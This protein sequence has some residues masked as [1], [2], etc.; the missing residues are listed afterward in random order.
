MSNTIKIKRGLDIKLKG[1]A[2]QVFGDAPA[3]TTYALK[4][5]DF[6][7]LTPKLLVKEGHEVKAGDPLFFSKEN[8]RV[9]FC[10]PVSGEVAEIRRGAKRKILEV[11]VLADKEIKYKDFGT[12]SPTDTSRE[13]I[14][15]KMLES[16]TWPFITQRPYGTI[17]N[18]EDKPKAVF[19]SGFDTSPMAPNIEFQLHGDEDAFKAGIEVMKKLTEGKVHISVDGQASVPKV[20]SD[21]QGVEIHKFS[22][23]HPAGNVGVQ[24]H[25]IAP[26]NKGEK[27]WTIS[28]TDLV[29]VGKLFTVGKYMPMRHVALTGSE[30][31]KPRY[32]KMLQGANLENLF[33]ENVSNQNVRYI[34][35]NVYTG[36]KIEKQGFLGF[37]DNQVSVIPEGDYAEFL[38]WL[39][40]RGEK[41]SLSRTFLSWLKPNKEYVLDTN[42]HG[43]ERAF[44]ITGELEEVFPF[45]IYPMQLLKSIMVGDIDKMEQL[46]I[47]EVIEEDMA[48]CEVICTSKIDIQDTLRDGLNMMKKELG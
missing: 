20:F 23:P 18:P 17:A 4:P 40:P 32:Y 33:H 9:K 14:I 47:Y 29:V 22:G 7:G 10:S 11:V 28:P 46:G 38:G 6:P 5:T 21:C 42:M 30:V 31:S 19:I 37:K 8:E 48:L 25:H 3:S 44:V 41:F 27:V 34:S 26:I 24:I 43:E 12:S 16:G 39:I 15:K 13:D 2:E 36:K 35:G 45:D 1:K